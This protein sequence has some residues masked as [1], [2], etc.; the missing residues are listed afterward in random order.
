M[1][2]QST[3]VTLH[4]AHANGFPA[5]SYQQLFNYLPS[6]WRILAMPKFAHSNQY[7]LKNNWPHQGQ[8]LLDFVF[9][10]EDAPDKVYLV[11]HSMGAIISYIGASMQPER[12]K[13][14]ILLDPPALMGRA[15]FMFKVLKKTKFIDK[16][17]PAGMA[18][19]RRNGWA[20]NTDLVEYFK[21][22]ALFRHFDERCIQDY[23][24]AVMAEV[25]GEYRLHF[26]PDVEAEIF[27]SVP[28]NLAKWKGMLQ[29]PRLLV[30]SRDGPVNPPNSRNAFIKANNL[31]HQTHPGTHMFPMEHP[32]SVA[33][34]ITS[35]ITQWEQDL[36]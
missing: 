31:Q 5:G 15:R 14:L 6:H 27:R 23:V 11:G 17:T 2:T 36:G 16:L 18:A 30:T 21:Q 4:F 1:T 13:G 10:R 22:K 33:A 19:I 35:T 7:P 24:N 34:L 25:K 32:E 12:V 29:C 26:E 28:D 20:I 8:E 3:G 9:D